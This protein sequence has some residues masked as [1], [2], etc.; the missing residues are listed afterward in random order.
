MG[1]VEAFGGKFLFD[2]YIG[3]LLGCVMLI[4]VY[5]YILTKK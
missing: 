2:L 1:V 5:T 3:I 4:T